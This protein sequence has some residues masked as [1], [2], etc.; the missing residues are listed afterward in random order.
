MNEPLSRVESPAV[1]LPRDDVDTD[2]IIPA[3]FL[4][5]VDRAGLGEC[6]FADWR[7]HPDGSLR[8]DVWLNH[9]DAAGRQILVAGRNFG[10]GS[11]R[12][13]AVWALLGAGFRVVVAGSFGDIFRANALKNGLLPVEVAPDRLLELHELLEDDRGRWLAVDLEAGTLTVPGWDVL[14]FS[15]DAFSRRMLLAGS[16]ELGYLL[17]LEP[18]IEAYEARHPGPVS[19]LPR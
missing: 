5:G 2:Q 15:I 8:S 7:R 10:C 16:D 17:A 3:R 1:V 18:A 9:P 6:L 12:E 14:P 11:S 13:H 19:T 4:K